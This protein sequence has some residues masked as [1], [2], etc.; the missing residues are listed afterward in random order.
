MLWNRLKNNKFLK[1]VAVLMSGTAIA[2]IITFS[3]MPI[4]TRIYGPEPIGVL[5]TY[6]AIIMFLGPLVSLTYPIAI[7]LPKNDYKARSIAKLSFLISIFIGLIAGLVI[8]FLLEKKLFFFDFKIVSSFVYLLPI[9]ITFLSLQQI[10]EQWLIRKKLFNIQAK[11]SIFQSLTLNLSK[12]GVGFIYPYA[13]SLIIIQT[14]SIL[15]KFLLMFLMS[16]KS[17]LN[18]TDKH[19]IKDIIKIAK[20]Y[21][22]FP[23][24]R[25]PQVFINSISQ[26]I[27]VVL[28]ASYFGTATAGFYSLGKQV[29]DTPIQLLGKAVQDVFY[30]QINEFASKKKELTP[31]LFK[32]IVSLFII[33]IVPFGIIIIFGPYIFSLVF[34]SQW[35][36]AGEYARWISLVSLSMLITR[37][38]IVSIPVLGI[39]KQLLLVEIIGTIGKIGSIL[40]AIN[41]LREPIYAVILFSV[42]SALMYLS[43]MFITFMKSKQFDTRLRQ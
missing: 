31:F 2:Q 28:F 42:T 12:I 3:L 36:I 35:G 13:I 16:N 15:F 22:D 4:I 29:L 39:Q 7:V 41:F 9:L 26:G 14:F 30:P 37:P 8:L 6:S 38:V 43:L 25:A 24:Y 5:G 10:M 18:S 17:I 32:A 21:Y 23:L 1:N 11:T 27:P 20:E 34:G 40:F 19:K 33:G